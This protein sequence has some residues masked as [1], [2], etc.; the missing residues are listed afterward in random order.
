MSTP[1]PGLLRKVTAVRQSGNTWVFT[2]EQAK[3]DEVM[4]LNMTAAGDKESMSQ[5][6]VRSLDPRFRASIG[7]KYSEMV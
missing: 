4:A 6:R 5:A 7:R 3:I 2:T 1:L